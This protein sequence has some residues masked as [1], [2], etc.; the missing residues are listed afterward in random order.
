MRHDEKVTRSKDVKPQNNVPEPKL[1]VPIDPG[2]CPNDCSL[3]PLLKV[4]SAQSS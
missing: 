1:A 3:D 2:G 4:P